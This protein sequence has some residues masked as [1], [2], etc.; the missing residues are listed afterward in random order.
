LNSI[1]IC[2]YRRSTGEK[3]LGVL[4]VC[5]KGIFHLLNNVYE[6][7]MSEFLE[8]VDLLRTVK[9]LSGNYQ[10]IVIAEIN[11]HVVRISQMTEPYFWHLHPDSDET[12]LGLEGTVVLELEDHRV[13]LNAGQMFTVPKGVKHRTAPAGARSVNLTIERADMTT[14][15]LEEPS[16]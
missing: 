7:N 9:E 11:D 4:A 6:A 3:K 14:V 1:S 13:E 2:S 16:S 15:K 10:N 5:G 12:F 8:V